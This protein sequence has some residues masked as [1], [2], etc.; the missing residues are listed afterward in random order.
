VRSPY[1]SL[2]IAALLAQS[3]GVAQESASIPAVPNV[4]PLTTL[5]QSDQILA[6]MKRNVWNMVE[7]SSNAPSDSDGHH[8]ADDLAEFVLTDE[9]LNQYANLR[10][11]VAQQL[12]ARP[13][14]DAGAILQPLQHLLLAEGLRTWHVRMHWHMQDARRYHL[15][16]VVPLLRK[17]SETQRQHAQQ[18]LDRIDALIRAFRAETPL[19]P[20]PFT[21]AAGM[22]AFMRW[23]NQIGTFARSYND[24]RQT[25]LSQLTATERAALNSSS[26]ERTE[27]CPALTE[28]VPAGEKLR[29]LSSPDIS[30]HYPELMKQHQVEGSVRV[31][32]RVSAEHCLMQAQV[33]ETSGSPELD[34]AALGAAM[35]MQLAAPVRDG[36]TQEAE[37]VLPFHFKLLE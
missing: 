12:A 27:P 7:S 1:W 32:V 26:T 17:S 5:E 31:R 34:S 33:V 37:G 3:A 19:V 20:Q 25:L 14:D 4:S 11:E 18:E 30:K 6:S 35:Q 15:G 28:P 16:I 36:K 13:Q 24:I 21:L 29:I 9:F 23:R 2:M 8:L 22:E 10:A